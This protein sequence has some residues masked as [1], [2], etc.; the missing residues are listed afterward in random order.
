MRF[1]KL[2]ISIFAIHSA[3]CHSNA[4]AATSSDYARWLANLKGIAEGAVAKS[5]FVNDAEVL[6]ALEFNMLTNCEAAANEKGGLICTSQSEPK[7][8][9]LRMPKLQ[10]SGAVYLNLSIDAQDQNIGIN[11]LIAE[12]EWDGVKKQQNDICRFTLWKVGPIKDSATVIQLRSTR[13]TSS[14][15]CDNNLAGIE[16]IISYTPFPF[17]SP[18]PK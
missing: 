8:Y 18:I 11:D 10:Q 6:K 2:L 4:V 1:L 12:I 17:P 7:Q 9:I 15:G 3:L 13:L 16:L 5:G 14:D